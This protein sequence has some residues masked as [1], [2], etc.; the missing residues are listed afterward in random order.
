MICDKHYNNITI[1]E[2]TF[3]NNSNLSTLL[4]IVPINTL[5]AN[6][7]LTVKICTFQQNYV[8]QLIKSN[9]HVRVLWQMSHYIVIWS[10]NISLNHYH[11]GLGLISLT[12]GMI[13]FKEHVII[14]HNSYYESMLYLQLSIVKFL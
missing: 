14:H 7:K 5:L 12:N 1:I 11:S 9:S 6:V 4:S 13:K 8:A 2:T 3:F 10:T